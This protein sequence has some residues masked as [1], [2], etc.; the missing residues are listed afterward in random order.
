M[1]KADRY[2]DE[3]II[4]ADG[5]VYRDGKLVLKRFSLFISFK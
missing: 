3:P 4:L 1:A 5:K 2:N